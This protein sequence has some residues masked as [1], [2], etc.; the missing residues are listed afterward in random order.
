M[1][2]TRHIRP[3][4]Y[5]YL[6]VCSC[7]LIL[8]VSILNRHVVGQVAFIQKLLSVALSRINRFKVSP[9]LSISILA[10]SDLGM[11]RSTHIASWSSW[12]TNHRHSSL[13]GVTMPLPLPRDRTYH[14]KPLGWLHSP[15]H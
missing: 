3:K 1:L 4:K 6:L 10:K 5:S 11:W 15:G 7:C 9:W 14:R 8:V 2:T 12:G 13:M